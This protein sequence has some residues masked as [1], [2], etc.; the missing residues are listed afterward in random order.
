MA[1]NL[2]RPPHSLHLT[3]CLGGLITSTL[4]VDKEE[5]GGGVSVG[6]SLS[7]TWFVFRRMQNGDAQSGH[8]IT[9]AS[10]LIS[11]SDK[12]LV[13]EVILEE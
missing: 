6:L 10:A 12:N 11:F 8:A 7:V 3:V 5:E 2:L 9:E 4:G 1:R 13:T